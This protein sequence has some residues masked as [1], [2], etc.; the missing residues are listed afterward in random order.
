VSKH[1]LSVDKII[2]LAKVL[3]VIKT[4]VDTPA[5]VDEEDAAEGGEAATAPPVYVGFIANG[6]WLAKNKLV[7]CTTRADNLD[8]GGEWNDD[9][10]QQEF[11]QEEE[12]VHDAVVDEEDEEWAENEDHEEKDAVDAVATAFVATLTPPLICVS[13]NNLTKMTSRWTTTLSLVR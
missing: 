4:D 9:I 3:S 5:M 2:G 6:E 12:A 7:T 1:D 8:I 11:A 13:T 10:E